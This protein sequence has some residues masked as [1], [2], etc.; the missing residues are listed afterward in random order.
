VPTVD[1]EGRAIAGDRRRRWT[2]HVAGRRAGPVTGTDGC[3][4][5]NPE[6]RSG[7]S[8]HELEPC[9]CPLVAPK[10]PW[11]VMVTD[12]ADDPASFGFRLVIV[13]VPCTVKRGTPLLA[14][15][16]D[17]HDHAAP[18]SRLSARGRRCWWRDQ[19]VGVCSGAVEGESCSC[20]WLAPK[21]GAGD[22]HRRGRS[23]R[24]SDSELVGRWPSAGSGEGDAVCW[25]RRPTVTTTFTGGRASPATG[26]TMLVGGPRS[27][28]SAVVPLKGDGAR[29]L[30]GAEVWCPVTV[31]DRADRS[32]SFGF[33]LVNGGRRAGP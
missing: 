13:G 8:C 32:A 7:G 26:T 3:W 31:T 5:S 23:R 14:T 15:T 27:L 12:V 21:L 2:H 30:R 1:G 24:S 20:L 17:G 29:A 19:A 16:A 25:R 18:L 28:G 11:P 4:S 9:S 6:V 22:G 10:V 33:R